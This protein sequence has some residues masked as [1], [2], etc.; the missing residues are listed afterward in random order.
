[1]SNGERDRVELGR[2]VTEGQGTEKDK[3]FARRAGVSPELVWQIKH[4]RRRDGKDWGGPSAP[5]VQAV[6]RAAGIPE[7]KA[8]RLAGYN[9]DRY[10]TPVDDGPPLKSEAVLV[11]EIR[12][13]P[14]PDRRA[15]E[16]LVGSLRERATLVDRVDALLREGGYI[17][18]DAPRPGPGSGVEVE[19]DAEEPGNVTGQADSEFGTP[20]PSRAPVRESGSAGH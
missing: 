14:V 7:D 6:A 20:A 2:L 13:L 5:H 18:A 16:Q 17:A 12:N 3:P 15:V 4:A 19:H 11:Q 10:I 9:P 1:M 8:L